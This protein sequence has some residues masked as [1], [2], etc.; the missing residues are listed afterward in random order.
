MNLQRQLKPLLALSAFGA[1]SGVLCG[2]AWPA[3][4]A[5]ILGGA[6]AAALFFAY[7]YYRRAPA[8]VADAPGAKAEV[9]ESQRKLQQRLEAAELELVMSERRRFQMDAYQAFSRRLLSNGRFDELIDE[10]FDYVSSN[11]GIEASLLYL[12][13]RERGDLRH[14]RSRFPDFLDEE[15]RR[16]AINLR[17]PLAAHASVHAAAVRRR[18]PFYMPHVRGAPSDFDL[19]GIA[20]MKLASLLVVPL[21]VEEELLGVIDF[22]NHERPLRLSR[23]D[24]HSITTFCEQIATA[25]KSMLLV[26]EAESARLRA[27]SLRLEAERREIELERHAAVNRQVNAETNLDAALDVIFDFIRSH[28]NAD[29]IWLQFLDDQANELYTYRAARPES[30]SEEHYRFI[31]G[32][33]IPLS[34]EGGIA[35]RV[36]QRRRPFYMPRPPRDIVAEIDRRIFDMLHLQ[37]AFCAP[38]V[39]GGEPIGVIIVTRFGGRLSL[40]RND[41]RSIGR[42]CDQIAGAIN[43]ARIHT[44]SEISRL[45]AEQRLEEVQLLKQQ[46]DLDYYLTANLLPPLTQIIGGR[47]VAIESFVRQKKRFPFKRWIC[48]IGGDLNMARPIQVGAQ[49]AQFFLNADSMGKSIQGAGGALVLASAIRT[50]LEREPEPE[51]SPEQWLSQ[52]YSELD[53]VFQ[54]FDGSMYVTFCMGLIDEQNGWAYWLNGEHP[55]PLLLRDGRAQLLRGHSMHKL[56]FRLGVRPRAVNLLRLHPGDALILGSDGRDD[57]MVYSGGAQVMN[58]REELFVETLQ[59]A[60]PDLESV[61]K[62]LRERGSVTDDVSLLRIDYAGVAAEAIHEWREEELM[63]VLRSFGAGEALPPERFEAAAT[64][65]LEIGPPPEDEDLLTL[66]RLMARYVQGFLNA[67]R[68]DRARTIA[69]HW[70]NWNPGASEQLTLAARAALLLG[71]AEESVA[72]A[73]RASLRDPENA[74]AFQLLAEA[75]L[76]NGERQLARS[77]FEQLRS[78][79]PA[80]TDALASL[81]RRLEP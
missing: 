21:Y 58:D 14:A 41:L 43:K 49:S 61:Y 13:D 25:V 65:A 37:S 34:A 52:A 31:L 29:G 70:L 45:M 39:I 38:L 33:R 32:L 22:T 28:Y 30:V 2:L 57:I 24:L 12:H 20:H 81:A 74:L 1:A 26:E 77:A 73:S 18:K 19:Q 55:A 59:A 42:F 11:F 4:E 40:N 44:S 3:P 27:E 51:D 10:I 75:R 46:Q 71:R 23:D 36:Y 54:N 60:G 67:N 9:N 8:I 53:A 47:N 63:S 72:L 56:G 79:K 66:D 48:E 69:L 50:L 76:E 5:I 17:L 64:R 35:S 6:S 7:L 68:A 78:L 16:Y 15:R 80:F 62:G